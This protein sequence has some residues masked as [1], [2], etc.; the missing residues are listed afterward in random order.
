LGG[1]FRGGFYLTQTYQAKAGA[2]GKYPETLTVNDRQ[3]NMYAIDSKTGKL[4][5]MGTLCRRKM[6]NPVVNFFRIHQGAKYAFE[7]F[8]TVYGGP[9]NDKMETLEKS[10]VYLSN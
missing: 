7:S 9:F 10:T 6:Q 2:D 8:A 5:P 4:S 3:G 1:R